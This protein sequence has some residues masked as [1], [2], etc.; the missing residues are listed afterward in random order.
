MP[1]KARLSPGIA[2]PVPQA[3]CSGYGDQAVPVPGPALPVSRIGWLL[4]GKGAAMSRV[5]YTGRKGK[6]CL[7]AGTGARMTRVRYT[8]SAGKPGLLPGTGA[9]MTRVRYTYSEGKLSLS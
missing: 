3:G 8:Y 7:L 2:G 9:R 1:V 6:P 5:T 4:P